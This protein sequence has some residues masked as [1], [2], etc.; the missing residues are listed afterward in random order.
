MLHT[1]LA[2]DFAFFDKAANISFKVSVNTTP[3][4]KLSPHQ[5]KPTSNEVRK[6]G[7]NTGS[8]YN[9]GQEF[10]LET[11]AKHI[12]EGNLIV[13]SVIDSTVV[14]KGVATTASI[15][16]IDIDNPTPIPFVESPFTA[17]RYPSPSFKLGVNSKHRLVI[18]LSEPIDLTAPALANGMTQEQLYHSIV[19]YLVKDFPKYYNTEKKADVTYDESSKKPR[20]FYWGCTFP[21]HLEMFPDA[22]VFDVGAYIAELALKCHNQAA[23]TDISSLTDTHKPASSAS[24]NQSA[25]S[26]SGS[27]DDD[28]ESIVIK[29]LKYICKEVWKKKCYLRDGLYDANL[30]YNLYEHHW[31]S[32][33]LES[34]MFCNFRGRRFGIPKDEE[35]KGGWVYSKHKDLPPLYGSRNGKAKHIFEYFR[36]YHLDLQAF[37]LKGTDFKYVVAFVCAYYGIPCYPFDDKG[38]I[39]FNIYNYM[40]SKLAYNELTMTVEY[41]GKEIDED[42]AYVFVRNSCPLPKQSS[43]DYV[44]EC[45]LTEAY[46]SSY[47]PI[48]KYLDE[49]PTADTSILK[50][51]STRYLGTSNF[52]YDDMLRKTLIAAVARQYEPG[53]KVDTCLVFKGVQGIKKSSF[54]NTLTPDSRW[55]DDTFRMESSSDSGQKDERSKLRKKWILEI[56]ELDTVFSQKETAAYRTLFTTRTD[57]HRVP[58]GRRVKDYPRNSIF[59]G[60]VNADTFLSD[61]EGNRR[62]WVIDIPKTDEIDVRRLVV[63]RDDIWAAAKTEYF[64]HLDWIKSGKNPDESPYK[65]WFTK[66][67]NEAVNESNKNF[68]KADYFIDDVL[69]QISGREY[70]STYGLAKEFYNVQNP[71]KDR[72]TVN[73]ITS[74]LKKSGWI[75]KMITTGDNK[76]SNGWFN[77]NWSDVPPG[78]DF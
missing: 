51:L 18:L 61:P 54:F 20:Q 2:Q 5:P 17:I 36:D 43:R 7:I 48:V 71:N 27:E 1:I 9:R 15:V 68:E 4:S 12:K 56:Q 31:Y 64:N 60:T 38:R 59:V 8:S 30:F 37:T 77:P 23:L 69:P 21:E 14:S 57:S 25:D 42:T 70:V 41:K 52:L 55:F 26:E 50:D 10:T 19:E 40:G 3:A 76:G 6:E 28:S 63:E 73:H 35:S 72:A 75:K 29:C 65:W 74:S 11:Y 62:Y 45:L 39:H 22:L 78:K 33:P 16:I 58:Y 34:D 46:R 66:G 67:E 13:P 32:E 24:D 44:M 53:C 47:H 49:L